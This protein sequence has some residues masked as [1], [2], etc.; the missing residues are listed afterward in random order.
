MTT[1]QI[2]YIDGKKLLK[3]RPVSLKILRKKEM[4]VL[5]ILKPLLKYEG[6]RRDLERSDHYGGG[7]GTP[8]SATPHYGVPTHNR[9]EPL[10]YDY[11]Q[12]SARGSHNMRGY[13]YRWGY[14][15]SS[16]TPTNLIS[17]QQGAEEVMQAITIIEGIF[18]GGDMVVHLG[19]QE[20]AQSQGSWERSI[21]S[22]CE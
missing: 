9:F 2:K 4:L 14:G 16:W 17:I 18:K 3:N 7:K 15:D 13:D 5:F 10:S 21:S 12:H 22:G 11:S 20:G 1:N 6:Q 19:E 8:Q